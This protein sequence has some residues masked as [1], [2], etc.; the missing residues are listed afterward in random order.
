MAAMSTVQPSPMNH[1]DR[2]KLLDFTWS[3]HVYGCSMAAAGTTI[4]D[5]EGLERTYPYSPFGTGMFR[6]NPAYRI[7]GGFND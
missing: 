6:V 4:T 2:R 3:A 1:E 5:D 7:D